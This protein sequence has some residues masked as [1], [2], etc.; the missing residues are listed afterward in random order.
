VNAIFLAY[1][2]ISGQSHFKNLISPF[3]NF[4]P[5]PVSQEVFVGI[6]II[7][8]SHRPSLFRF[9]GGW[10]VGCSN[11]WVLEIGKWGLENG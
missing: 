4:F 1:F 11:V 8:Y 5:A 9:L 2:S 6:C 7:K 10:L 3:W